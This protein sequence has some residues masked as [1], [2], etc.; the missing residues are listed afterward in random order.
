MP[1]LTNADLPLSLRLRLS[2]HAQ[3]I[4]R[5]AFNNAWYRYGD[6]EL[7]RLDEIAHRVASASVKKKYCKSGQ[8]WVPRAERGSI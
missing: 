6:S 8:I 1:Y 5:Q 2:A 3:D 4:Y 7:H